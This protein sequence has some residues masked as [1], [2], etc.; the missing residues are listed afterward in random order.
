M[1][2]VKGLCATG[3][4]FLL[5]ACTEYKEVEVG[6][7]TSKGNTGLENW[8]KIK[9]ELNNYI[10]AYG[11]DRIHKLSHQD[12]K[13]IVKIDQESELASDQQ[14]IS[15][16]KRFFSSNDHVGKILIKFD[17]LSLASPELIDYVSDNEYIANELSGDVLPELLFNE[18]SREVTCVIKVPLANV[19][20]SF[21]VHKKTKER[22]AEERYLES[23]GMAFEPQMLNY[24]VLYGDS[25]VFPFAASDYE[26]TTEQSPML[27]NGQNFTQ[28]FLK[29][30]LGVL[31]NV[32][33]YTTFIDPNNSKNNSH[34]TSSSH[35]ARCEKLIDDLS[36]EQK[37]VLRRR[38]MNI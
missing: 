6:S 3:I 16:V 11:Y 13:I 36:G 32:E 22:I 17:D 30:H 14:F 31:E 34:A 2:N 9:N 15:L 10:I 5:M 35:F 1:I 29:V 27:Y 38:K 25:E 37:N 4:V 26:I 20:P 24:Q 19:M 33:T 18:L 28:S 8:L 21:E 23:L 12:N 7:V